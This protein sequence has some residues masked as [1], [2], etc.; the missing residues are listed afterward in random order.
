MSEKWR[1]RL[2]ELRDAILGIG[3]TF[4]GIGSAVGFSYFLVWII[5]KIV[6]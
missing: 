4:L 6:G 5:L 1:E 2:T 3:S